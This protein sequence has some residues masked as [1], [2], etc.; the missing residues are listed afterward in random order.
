PKQHHRRHPT[1]TRSNRQQR[2]ISLKDCP[3]SG[4]PKRRLANPATHSCCSIS[5]CDGLET[6]SDLTNSSFTAP[7]PGSEKLRSPRPQ[8]WPRR[9]G[10]SPS[11]PTDP[12]CLNGG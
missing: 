7:A 12:T 1:Q 5:C 6:P 9:G 10:S 3:E 8:F 11:Q 4:R 2:W